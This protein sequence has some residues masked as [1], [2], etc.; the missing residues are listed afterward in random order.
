MELPRTVH[1]IKIGL[2]E[3]DGGLLASIEVA[4][5]A[6]PTATCKR[7]QYYFCCRPS[8]AAFAVSETPSWMP[9]KPRRDD[10]QTSFTHRQGVWSHAKA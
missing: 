5:L 8:N 4:L 10:A 3:D 6:I 2:R 9:S 1:G 7:G